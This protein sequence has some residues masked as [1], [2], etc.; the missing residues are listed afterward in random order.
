[1]FVS[2][3]TVTD[4]TLTGILC[5]VLHDFDSFCDITVSDNTATVIV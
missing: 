5:V 2:D 4:S 3:I 1:M